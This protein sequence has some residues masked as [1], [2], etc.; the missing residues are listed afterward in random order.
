MSLFKNE[1]EMQA[2][3]LSELDNEDVSGLADLILPVELID[4]PSEE[5]VIAKKYRYCLDALNYN[6]F[7]SA[8][9]DIS[10]KAGDILRPDL[11]MYSSESQLLVVVE[12]K[13][14]KEPTRQAG[15]EISA[16]AAEIRS[17]LPLLAGSDIVNV[18]VSVEW[19]TLL[20][21]YVYNEIMWHQRNILCLEPVKCGEV[22]R[23][24]VVQPSKIIEGD[25]S[26]RLGDDHLGG[27]HICLYDMGLYSG[28]DPER[29]SGHM[30]QMLTAMRYIASKGNSQG[31]NGFAFFWKNMHPNSIAP[32]MIT[33]VNIAPFLTLER[34]LKVSEV[35]AGSV[36]DRFIDIC[37]EHDPRGHGASIGEQ[38][39]SAIGFL[40]TICRPQ[41]EGFL[42]WRNLKEFM[43]EYGELLAFQSWGFFESAYFDRLKHKYVN[44]AVDTASNDPFLALEMLDELIDSDY[45]Y[46]DMAY[47]KYDPLQDDIEDY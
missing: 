34:F 23:L 42:G 5:E 35:E 10:L 28:G 37:V 14:I 16:Y 3:L 13:N 26:I 7:I 41:P 33:I 8:D 44:G 22:I 4:C 6:Y 1:A 43:I 31:N 12:L 11:L 38:L 20:R 2:W 24:Q 25:A 9:E 47:Y 36:L 30:Q 27:F 15:T 40:E 21:H 46:I 18:I 17:Y 29:L 32:Y 45:E 39:T 19:P